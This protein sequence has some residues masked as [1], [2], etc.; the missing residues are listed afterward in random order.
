ML[1]TTVI[2]CWACCIITFITWA[3][4]P[5]LWKFPQ[6]TLLFMTISYTV[7]VF[8]VSLPIFTGRGTAYCSHDDMLSSWKDPTIVCQIQGILFHIGIMST[9]V[10]WLCSV[11]N[12]FTASYSKGVDNVIVRRPKCVFLVQLLL[13]ITVPA[14][15]VAVNLAMEG[16]Y[17]ARYNPEYVVTCSPPTLSLF[18]YTAVMPAQINVFTGCI[19]TI[20]IIIRLHK[21]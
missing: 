5:E 17:K 20:M 15:L 7:V 11:I 3:S 9:S 2:F 18:Y 6:N 10:W 1:Y 16:S 14:A 13:S 4:S 8:S 12:V 19:L 21:V